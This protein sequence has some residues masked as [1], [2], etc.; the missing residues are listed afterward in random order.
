MWLCRRSPHCAS[1]QLW[2]QPARGG[3]K[4]PKA[5]SCQPIALSSPPG[6]GGARRG[7]GAR[8]QLC[9]PEGGNRWVFDLPGFPLPAAVRQT[10]GLVCFVWGGLCGGEGDIKGFHSTFVVLREHACSAGDT[11]GLLSSAWYW[12]VWAWEKKTLCKER[13]KALPL[14]LRS[15]WEPPFYSL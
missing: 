11:R 10:Q 3:Y 8:C 1:G 12:A 15:L 5:A 6:P 7:V 4:C 13:R 9:G 2:T 14:G